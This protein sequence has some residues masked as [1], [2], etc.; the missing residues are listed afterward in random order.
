MVQQEKQQNAPRSL[1]ELHGQQRH[2]AGGFDCAGRERHPQPASRG[3]DAIAAPRQEAAHPSKGMKQ[4]QGR[5]QVPP[6]GIEGEPALFAEE[7]GARQTA[8]QAAIENEP[9]GEILCHKGMRGCA[10]QRQVSCQLGE[11]REQI[12]EFRA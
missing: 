3:R 6:Q 7:P 4:R 1:I 2:A 5:N 8:Q 9:P 11:Q 10:E 12:E